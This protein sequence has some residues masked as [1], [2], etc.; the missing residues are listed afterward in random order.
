MKERKG[1][2]PFGDAGQLILLGLLQVV[3]AWRDGRRRTR[4]V[5]ECA[6]KRFIL[7]PSTGP[8]DPDP[9]DRVIENYRVFMRT[10]REYPWARVRRERIPA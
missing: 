8:F 4:T 3:R 1:E 7:S 10:A 2:H 9:S 6:G 5:C